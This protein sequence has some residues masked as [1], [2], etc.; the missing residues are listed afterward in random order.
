MQSNKAFLLY[1]DLCFYS[2]YVHICAV[3]FV[4]V[5][6]EKFMSLYKIDAAARQKQKVEWSESRHTMPNENH[7]NTF[8]LLI[9]QLIS[10]FG[11][12]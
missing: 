12:F 5:L 2:F 4:F 8:I 11:I 9:I 1:I 10:Q 3:L 6:E 7:T